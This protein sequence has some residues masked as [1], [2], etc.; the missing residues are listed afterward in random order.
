M[1]IAEL[2]LKP[3]KPRPPMTLPQARIA[4]LKQSIDRDKQR[5]A[6]ERETQRRQR[7]AEQQRK[8]RTNP[9]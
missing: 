3:I 4:G 2:T 9:T 7:R 6:Q 8:H 5:L 1:R